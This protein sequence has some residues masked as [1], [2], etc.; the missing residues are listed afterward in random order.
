MIFVFE[1]HSKRADTLNQSLLE[2]I[3]GEK[4][5]NLKKKFR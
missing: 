1:L 3:K 2:N 5:L 4:Y